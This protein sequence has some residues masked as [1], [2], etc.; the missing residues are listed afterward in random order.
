MINHPYTLANDNTDLCYFKGTHNMEIYYWLC[1]LSSPTS[2][3]KQSVLAQTVCSLSYQ[4]LV[5]GS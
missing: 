2:S 5:L 4:S 1:W 3:C